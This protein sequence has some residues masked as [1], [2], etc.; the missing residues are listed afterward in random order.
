MKLNTLVCISLLV[1]AFSG[2]VHGEDGA[3]ES[4]GESVSTGFAGGVVSSQ[5]VAMTAAPA[6]PDRPDPQDTL[7]QLRT[8]QDSKFMSRYLR[9]M[10]FLG[11]ILAAGFTLLRK[12][13]TRLPGANAVGADMQVVSRL[14]L[15]Q[16]TTLFVVRMREE[17]L[18]LASGAAGTRL[19]ARYP[20]RE[21]N[22]SCA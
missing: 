3:A 7:L 12:F 16:R 2:P 10:L 22:P 17:E 18:L 4:P 8:G 11:A 5:H 20:P 1:A 14:A 9:S 6:D 19:V 13:R 15:D 21:E